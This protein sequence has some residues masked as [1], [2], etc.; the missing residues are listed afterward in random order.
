MVNL[1]EIFYDTKKGYLSLDKFYKK[2]KLID[3]SIT[4]KD[5]KEFLDNQFTTQVNKDTKKPKEYSTIRADKIRDNYQIDIIVYDRYEINN[6]KYILCVVDVHSRYASCRA[7]T[8]RDNSVIL[9]YLKDIFS[10]MGIPKNINCDNEFNTKKLNDYFEKEGITMYY[11]EV[12]EINKNAI[13]ERFNKTLAGLLQKWRVG[14]GER[15]WYKV[16]DDLVRNYN[17]TYH[18]TIKATPL[19]VWN[20]KVKSKQQH[21]YVDYGSFEEGDKVRIKQIK[22]VLGKGDYIRYSPNVYIVEKVKGNQIT[23]IGGK[24]LYKPFELRKVGDIQYK[25]EEE[26]EIVLPTKKKSRLLKEIEDYNKAPTERY[27][28]RNRR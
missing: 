19:E 16:L 10:K 3:N 8:S 13:V 14:S 4:L 2:V 28:L 22:S 17:E 20:G 18:T 15:R 12:G 1:K 26:E 5:V 11:S 24:R 25:E 6:Y 27:N 9:A 7:M 21:K 23:L